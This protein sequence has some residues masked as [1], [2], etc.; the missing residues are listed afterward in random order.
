VPRVRTEDSPAGAT[1]IS[2]ISL[3]LI[4][5]T[6]LSIVL[7]K[8]LGWTRIHDDDVPEDVRELIRIRE[9][10]EEARFVS[11]ISR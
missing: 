8:A 4:L 3:I 6:G 9:S 11:W 10:E 7:K 2:I 1:K 5:W